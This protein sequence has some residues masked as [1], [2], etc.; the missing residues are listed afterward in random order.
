MSLR[1]CSFDYQLDVFSPEECDRILALGSQLELRPGDTHSDEKGK[2]VDVRGRNC[3]LEWVRRDQKDEWEWIFARIE[4]AA[5]AMNGKRWK[6]DVNP[7]EKIQY[8]SYTMAQFYA[9]HFD[10]GSSNTE[11]RK[12]SVTVQL[13]DPKKYWGGRLKLWSMNESK[14]APKE[15]GA[16]TVFPSYLL[17]VAKPVWRGRRE[18]LVSWLRGPETLS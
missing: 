15:R 16:M 6:F 3:E 14:L 7:P 18:V 17:H 4:E 2:R 8:T 1:L 5:L 10:N 12:L 13:T 11:H 9:A